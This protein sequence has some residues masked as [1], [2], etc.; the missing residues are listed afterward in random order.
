M[1]HLGFG[2]I[3]LLS[4]A[5]SHVGQKIFFQGNR[6]YILLRTSYNP[7]PEPKHPI[8]PR[9]GAQEPSSS[10]EEIEKPSPPSSTEDEDRIIIKNITAKIQPEYSEEVVAKN[11]RL[12]SPPALTSKTGAASSSE[13]SAEAE[14]SSAFR[15]LWP[16]QVSVTKTKGGHG[17]LPHGDQFYDHYPLSSVHH[18]YHDKK[19]I[20]TDDFSGLTEKDYALLNSKA[21]WKYQKKKN[22]RQYKLSKKKQRIDALQKVLLYSIDALEN[23]FPTDKEAEKDEEGE[24]DEI[25]KLEL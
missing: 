22:K 20:L 15:F 13:S 8:S 25:G 17:H 24:D 10:E 18:H 5:G 19:K 16:F 21:Y 9:V 2:L 1:G 6:P 12:P 7:F 11:R 4:L 14:P 23:F 3:L